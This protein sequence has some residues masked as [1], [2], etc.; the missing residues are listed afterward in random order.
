[1]HGRD[2]N[3]GPKGTVGVRLGHLSDCLG[4]WTIETP[5]EDRSGGRFRHTSDKAVHCNDGLSR[6]WS[7]EN[8][9]R[10]RGV[11]VDQV[12]LTLIERCEVGFN[13]AGLD[14]P[15][16]GQAVNGSHCLGETWETYLSEELVHRP[17]SGHIGNFGQD[18]FGL[19]RMFVRPAICLLMMVNVGKCNFR[20]VDW[21]Q[22]EP[23]LAVDPCGPERASLSSPKSLEVEPR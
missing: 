3:V 21:Y 14:V 23:C 9:T 10:Y 1:M 5:V 22:D 12:T 13:P 6:S 17:A 16:L 11:H 19:A 8:Q 7:T 2:L 20:L 18:G 4:T 15:E